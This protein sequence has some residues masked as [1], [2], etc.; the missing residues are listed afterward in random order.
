LT[1][2]SPGPGCGTGT[3]SI[4]RGLPKF[5]TTAAFIVGI[6]LLLGFNIR[7]SVDPL[8]AFDLRQR[9]RLGRVKPIHLQWDVFTVFGSAPKYH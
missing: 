2:T 3:S 8:L 1:S 9:Q 7:L 5:L 6:Y 4:A